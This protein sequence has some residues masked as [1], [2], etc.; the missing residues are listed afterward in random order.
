MK[1]TVLL[2]VRKQNE[3]IIWLA[4]LVLLFNMQTTSAHFSF[5]VFSILGFQH[6]PG[7]GIGHAIHYALHVDFVSSWKAHPFGIPATL[8]I[9]YRIYQLLL[10]TYKNNKH[11]RSTIYFPA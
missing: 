7:C 3:L 2:F 6:C 4:A 5:C 10:K 9:V 11:G 1:H 8:I